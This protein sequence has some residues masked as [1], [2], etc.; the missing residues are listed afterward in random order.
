MGTLAEPADCRDS[1]PE[2]RSAPQQIRFL[3][4]V[5]SE[6]GLVRHSLC[7]DFIQY[8]LFPFADIQ[9]EP[10]LVPQPLLSWFILKWRS[11]V[12]R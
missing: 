5:Q 4:V 9:I 8:T 1:H 11:D 10:N 3:I 6:T 7:P 12:L 2:S